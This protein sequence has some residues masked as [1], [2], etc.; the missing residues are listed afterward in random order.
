MR[1]VFRFALALLFV[2]AGAAHFL[3][4]KNYLAIMPPAIPWPRAMVALSGLAEIAGG[5]GICLPRTRRAAGWGLI[6]LLVAVFPANVYAISTGM[7]ISG[8]TVP[9]WMLWARLPF[10]FVFIYWV[11]AVCLR[12]RGSAKT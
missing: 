9:A 8:Y 3:A 1:A 10:Q 7:K 11:Y 5:V 6:A 2:V 4:P 12:E